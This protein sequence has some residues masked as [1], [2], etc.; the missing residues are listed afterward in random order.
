MISSAP[1]LRVVF[2]PRAAPARAPP[3]AARV[4]AWIG[5][6]R[7]ASGECIRE[8]GQPGVAGPLAKR[9]RGCGLAM[10]DAAVTVRG[11]VA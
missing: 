4:R 3:A 10:R 8:R 6:E 9:A 5:A 2:I 7:G 1:R 11:V